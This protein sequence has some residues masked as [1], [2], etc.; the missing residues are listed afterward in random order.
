[1]R[2]EQSK[3]HSEYSATLGSPPL[4]RGT[5][6]LKAIYWSLMGITPA[7]AGNSSKKN[8]LFAF[9]WDHPRL[10]GEQPDYAGHLPDIIGSP[11]LARGTAYCSGY[12]FAYLGITPA[13]AGNRQSMKLKYALY[14]DHPRL[15][16]EQHMTDD[17]TV[18][19]L[20]SP[21]LARGTVPLARKRRVRHGITPACAGNSL[22]EEGV[23]LLRWDHPRLR[24]EQLGISRCCH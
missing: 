4:A 16:G 22:D 13:C 12:G 9:D 20:G 21:P 14:Q 2:G 18:K 17:K 8:P 15:R 6:T 23:S 7:C 10:R 19:E 24:G 1:M 3:S 11:P 5:E